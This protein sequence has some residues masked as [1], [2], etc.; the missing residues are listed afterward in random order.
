MLGRLEVWGEE[1]R[2]RN[3]ISK[4]HWGLGKKSLVF[5]HVG[6][7]WAS[8]GYEWWVEA[9]RKRMVVA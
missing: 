2:P 9:V 1:F 4:I 7:G 6:G 8:G 5:Q 3:G